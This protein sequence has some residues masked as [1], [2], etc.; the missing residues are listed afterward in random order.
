M[1]YGTGRFYKYPSGLLHWRLDNHVIASVT[2]KQFWTVWIAK[3]L[4]PIDSDDIIT[5]Q[6]HERQL[7]NV[8]ECTHRRTP[9]IFIEENAFE[10]FV[11]EMAVIWSRPQC[12]N[13]LVVLG[14]RIYSNHCINVYYGRIAISWR[15]HPIPTS[16]T[17]CFTYIVRSI[18]NGYSA[19]ERFIW[20]ERLFDIFEMDETKYVVLTYMS[21]SPV[22]VISKDCVLQN[23]S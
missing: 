7:D 23:T 6:S 14:I 1:R 2:M 22:T 11:C 8:L 20:S 17:I 5:V 15:H 16:S 4:D 3:S 19:S 21:N 18:L 13:C 9:Y 10:G 12:L